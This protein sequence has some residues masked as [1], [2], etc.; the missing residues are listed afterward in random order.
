MYEHFN[1]FRVH[2]HRTPFFNKECK[3]RLCAPQHSLMVHY[4]I[5]MGWHLQMPLSTHSMPKQMWTVVDINQFCHFDTIWFRFMLAKFARHWQFSVIA[6]SSIETKS[7]DTEKSIRETTIQI[8]FKCIHH[9]T[10][11]LIEF[12][13][14]L[15]CAQ[16][17]FPR[18]EWD[19]Q[20]MLKPI[21]LPMH[22]T[23]RQMHSFCV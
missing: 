9:F 12:Q 20:V 3:L 5:I 11:H 8:L 22:Y 21:H 1:G 14:E 17:Y 2:S 6:K 19:L 15:K 4:V 18:I 23:F 7:T 10:Q 13:T 16:F